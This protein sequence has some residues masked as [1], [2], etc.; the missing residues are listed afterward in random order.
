[1]SL[2][3]LAIRLLQAGRPLTLT[4]TTKLLEAGIDVAALERKHAL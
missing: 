3:D 1:M 4:L 2:V